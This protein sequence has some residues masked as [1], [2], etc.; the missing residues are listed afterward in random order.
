MNRRLAK[1]YSFM[2]SISLVVCV[3]R[4]R[5]LLERLLR[6]S[7]G[8]YDELLVEHDIPDSQDVRSVV[9]AAGGRFFERPSASHQ[10]PQ[11]PFLWAQ[12]KNDWILRLDSDE[13]P[14]P[15]LRGWLKRFRLAAE[16]DPGISGYTCIWP[17]WDGQR[18]VSKKI[19]S[20]RALLFHRHRVRFFGLGEQSPIPDGRFETLDLVL[21]HQ[22]KR[23]SY[24]LH[25]VLVRK[26]SYAWRDTLARDLLGKPTDLPCWRWENET[27]PPHW[28][29]I[30]Q[31][32]LSTGLRRLVM[33]SFRALRQ[34]WRVEGRFFFEAALNGPLFH[35]LVCFQFWRIRRRQRP[36][37][38]SK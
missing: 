29:Q 37:A 13:F 12:A 2:P 35:A 3:H 20:G 22:P 28:E 26:E 33:E 1:N 17:L 18:T 16:P 4:Q 24:G 36:K 9:L 32:P 31:R 30:R 6:E 5:D 21:H 7:T 8:C 34:Q 25:N 10:E 38:P 15:E 19:W 23:K 14:G 27:W 11:W